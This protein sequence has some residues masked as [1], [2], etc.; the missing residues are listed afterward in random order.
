MTCDAVGYR[1]VRTHKLA[2]KRE[3]QRAVVARLD[4]PQVLL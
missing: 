2:N 3:N 1:A 4:Y